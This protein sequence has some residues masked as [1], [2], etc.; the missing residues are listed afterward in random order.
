MV[1]QLQTELIGN[2]SYIR[3][4]D[5]GPI[6]GDRLS[7]GEPEDIASIEAQNELFRSRMYSELDHDESGI[8]AERVQSFLEEYGLRL[9]PFIAVA[10]D[11]VP[12][13]EK[14]VGKQTSDE[15]KTIGAHYPSSDVTYVIRNKD[16]E[17]GNGSGITEAILVHEESHANRRR[18]TIIYM[19]DQDTI[20]S[21]SIRSGFNV[22]DGFNE[23]LGSYFEEGFAELLAHRY[24][25]E[26]LS[27]PN[28]FSDW[29]GAQT[30]RVGEE[31]IKIPRSYWFPTSRHNRFGGAPTPAFAAYGME[32][33]IAKD[34]AI[35]QAMLEARHSTDGLREFAQRVDSLDPGIY[36]LLRRQ[37]YKLN[38]FM[39]ATYYIVETLY[40]GDQDKAIATVVPAVA[41]VK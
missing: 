16:L 18:P 29:G 34:P 4:E 33:L 41:D 11:Q 27:K 21:Y 20:D 2:A 23:R 39:A 7:P 28:G 32:L 26:A 12:V 8:D 6:Y 22:D 19:R 14:I 15:G 5:N 31:E 40:G 1:N 36:R 9:H 37:P 24:V 35:F 3:V 30:V 25:T 38:N 17:E 13:L 10:T